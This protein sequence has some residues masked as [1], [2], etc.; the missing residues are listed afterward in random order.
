LSTIPLDEDSYPPVRLT[1]VY[2]VN[3]SFQDG[4]SPVLP[5]GRDYVVDLSVGR[6]SARELF[7]ELSVALTAATT[8]D[9][10]LRVS[11]A[12]GAD[13]VV[14]EEADQGDEGEREE[15]LRQTAYELAPAVLYSYIRQLFE[16]L[17]GRGRGERIT[18]PFL[19]MP[20]ELADEEKRIPPP[21]AES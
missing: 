10:P 4:G 15:V 19:P 7:V 3:A 6:R 12:Y 2:L 11:A 5:N 14:P 18:L 8:E 1:R 9:P 16:D 20:L 21:P 13:F 17:T